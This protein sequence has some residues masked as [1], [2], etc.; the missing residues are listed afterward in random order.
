MSELSAPEE[1]PSG[2]S[3]A[4]APIIHTFPD[5]SGRV[6]EVNFCKNPRCAN[7]GVASTLKKGAH[8]SKAAPAPGTEYTLNANSK[9]TPTLVCRLCSEGPPIKSNQ[10]V[11]E[12]LSRMM[13]YMVPPSRPSCPVEDC[14]NHTVPISS[15]T[16]HYYGNGKSD[17]GSPRYR[18][19]AC[20]KTFSTPATSTSRQRIPYKN[21]QIFKLL[22]NKSPLSRICEVA[23]VDIKTVYHRIDF[24][25]KQ[26]LA[27]VSRREQAFL[28]GKQLTGRYRDS[29]KDV[30]EFPVERLYLAVDRQSYAVNWTQR[31]DKRNVMLQAIGSADL[32]SG[33]VFGMHLNF[34]G[35]LDPA[36]TEQS[37]IAAGDYGVS[38]PF[39]TF[40]HLWLEPD[41]RLSVQETA[42][43]QAKRSK[44]KSASL[45]GDIA[46]GYQDTE[47]RKDVESPDTATA[48]DRLPRRGMQVRTEYTLYAHFFMLRQ[49][50]RGV[51]KIR[52]YLDQESGIRAACLCAFQEEVKAGNCEAFYVRISKEMMVDEKRKA[53][54]ESRALFNEMAST[55]HNPTPHEVEVMLML[56]EMER[57]AAIGKW[58]D[59]WLTHPMPNNSEP[60]KAI[61]Y[62]TETG[63]YAEDQEH[64]ANLY[65]KGSLHSID[66]FFMQ[67]RRRLSLVERP[68]GTPSKAGRT[69]YGYSAYQPENVQK[70][71]EIFRV[72]YNYCLPGKDKLTPAMRIGLAQTVVAPEDILYFQ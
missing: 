47:A 53:I 1:M 23:G 10:G 45:V 26:C 6:I 43:R 14:A 50:T 15:S 38:P 69:W 35:Q 56:Q 71:L 51:A 59:R 52:F 24:I 60:E 42:E 17:K 8:R 54:R 32:T 58:S 64:L 30:L 36:T 66:R 7:F 12:E 16:K 61:C 18:C 67:V 11:A 68:I 37:A 25:H 9:D 72:Y 49:L 13:G 39:R 63:R 19:R 22:M 65:L 44:A 3:K 31:K 4:P 29:A 5:G 34:N 20:G 40:A 70:M 33:Y 28:D 2:S 62:L 21:K 46:A 55:M 57:A 27:F 48:T 41:Y